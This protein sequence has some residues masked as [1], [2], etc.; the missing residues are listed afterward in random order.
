[1]RI[2]LAAGAALLI[3]SAGLPLAG[4]A[5]AQDRDCPEFQTQPEAQ[6]VFNMDRSDPN[7]LDADHDGIACESLPAGLPAAAAPSGGASPGAAASPAGPANT[8]TP[9][10]LVPPAP[11]PHGAVAAGT[12]PAESGSTTLAFSLGAAAAL[13]AGGA[14]AVRRRQAAQES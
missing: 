7:G 1:M 12:G 13:A 6:A 4:V 10:P 8:A 3:S 5:H 9:A 2:A 11:A 14:V